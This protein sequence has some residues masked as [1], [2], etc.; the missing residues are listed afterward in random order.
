MVIIALQS[1]AH[2]TTVLHSTAVMASANFWQQT[3]HY[4]LGSS[5]TK[6]PLKETGNYVWWK[7]KRQQ[8]L[9]T[10]F[11]DMEGHMG[12]VAVKQIRAQQLALII[13]NQSS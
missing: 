9:V 1:F 8:C 5:Q 12:W 13:V 6:F 11:P 2:V 3:S 7:K 4:G 10:W